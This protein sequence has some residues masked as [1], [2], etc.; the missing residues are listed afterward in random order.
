[1]RLNRLLFGLAIVACMSLYA[2][3]ALAQGGELV[4][5]E[6][7][8]PGSRVDVTARVR[9]FI[10]DG[11]LQLEVTRFNLGIDPAPHQNKDLII[12]V[13]HWNGEVE[14]YK[15]PERSTCTLE[16]GRRD[17]WEGREQHDAHEFREEHGEEAYDHQEHRLR[18][19]RA[20][21]GAEGQFVDVTDTLRSRIDDGRLYL[22]VDNYSLGVDPIPG[23]HKFLRVEYIHH[24][25]RHNIT[26]DEKTFL[27]LP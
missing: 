6:W 27:R 18:I 9:T 22:R 17:Q 16:L 26:V 7:G 19:L 2:T 10:H 25:E 4:R 3:S 23:V 13:R 20:D 8:V 11:I 1:M 5:A 24:G 21:Y 15:Y 12:R 14:E